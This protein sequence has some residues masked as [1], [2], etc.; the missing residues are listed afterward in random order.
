MQIFESAFLLK[1]VRR[2]EC[3]PYGS[4]EKDSASVG[5]KVTHVPESVY[6]EATLDMC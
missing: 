3:K 4:T 2:T 1:N 5:C 6:E